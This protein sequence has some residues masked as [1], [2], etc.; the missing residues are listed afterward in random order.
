[1]SKHSSWAQEWR[2]HSPRTKTILVFSLLFVFC[3]FLFCIA[4]LTSQRV[5]QEVTDTSAYL[6]FASETAPHNFPTDICQDQTVSIR[7]A[8]LEQAQQTWNL[9]QNG[10]LIGIGLSVL[11]LLNL[12]LRPGET[13]T[14]GSAHFATVE[15]VYNAGLIPPQEPTTETY[16][17]LG[18]LKNVLSVPI[19][20]D[21]HRQHSHVL[22]V[23]PTGQGKTSGVII[24]G[25]LNERGRRHV[26]IQ[27]IKGDLF[28]ACAGALNEYY[29]VRVFAPSRPAISQHYNPL[30]HI[31][32]VEDAVD[33]ARCWVE[34]TGLNHEEFWN[35]AAML[36]IAA[37][38]LH[39]RASEPH[40]PLSHLLDMLGGMSFDQ[41]QDILTATPSPEAQ[42]MTT[43]FLNSLSMNPKLAGSIM[44]E[45]ATR[46][47]SLITPSIQELT[48]T[49]DITFNLDTTKEPTALFLS[50]GVRDIQRLK[51]LSACFT[52]QLMK[53]S[54]E[55]KASQ[56]FYFDEFANAGRI[57][58]FLEYISIV[59]A[60]NKAF[61]LSIQDFGQVKREYEQ[62]GL[63]TILSNATTKIVFPGAN[64]EETRY[65]SEQI[66]ET[67]V[68]TKSVGGV[69]IRSYG[70]P[71]V[72][73]GE[74]GRRLMMPDEIRRMPERQLI[75]LTGN[76]SPVVITNTPYYQQPLLLELTKKTYVPLRTTV[77]PEPPP[78]KTNGQQ[79]FS[80]E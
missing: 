5:F 26:Y 69:D 42:R 40:A 17:P 31:D 39:L 3:V 36:L 77:T 12:V 32:T 33:F 48:A 47:L 11:I 75:M 24:P 55:S 43:T 68:K 72:T 44:V 6:G 65:F 49:N 15:E 35:N 53:K 1:M 46:L 74:T 14:H 51:P 18:K 38:V 10:S 7:A 13:T 56:V 76:V 45:L 61:V 73:E 8:C 70:F 78:T 28:T 50:I 59:R 64:L 9:L 29:D 25:I 57:T 34:N 60:E 19:A 4:F 41:L 23:A 21:E 16:L 54:L 66:G 58:H 2:T 79:Y 80:K 37:I 30:M 67:T 52:M 27:D 22:I 71:N 20:L 63:N 62:D